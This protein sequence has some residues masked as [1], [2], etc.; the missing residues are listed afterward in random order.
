MHIVD[1]RAFEALDS[2]GN[3][4]LE[5]EVAL[6][7][8]A[9][10]VALVP[11]GASTG[12]REA[13]ERRD[14]DPRRFHGRGVLDAARSVNTEV[15]DVLRDMRADRQ[16]DLDQAMIALDGT[17]DKSRLGANAIVGVSLAAAAAAASLKLPLW[18]YVGGSQA[19]VMPVPMINVLNGGAH[20][21]NSLDFQEFMVLPVGAASSPRRCAWAPKCSM[22]S[23][24]PETRRPFGQ[25]GRRGRLRA[26]SARGR[27]SAG[28]PDGGDRTGRTPARPGRR[29]GPGS[30]RQRISSARRLRLPDRTGA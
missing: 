29:A 15:R 11:S 9:C 22:R 16:T 12:I 23:G 6:S 19:C 10:G 25:R 20:A 27:G 2:R 17:P 24:R 18:R 7:D 1:I 30:G 13:C 28:L 3:P 4:T 21:D 26:R 5:V 8:G 14:G